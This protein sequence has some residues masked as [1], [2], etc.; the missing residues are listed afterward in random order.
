MLDYDA[1]AAH[2]LYL[3]S[4]VPGG[5]GHPEDEEDNWNDDGE[6]LFLFVDEGHG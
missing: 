2:V 3:T 6:F 1:L 5:T 4:P